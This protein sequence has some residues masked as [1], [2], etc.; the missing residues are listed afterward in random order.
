MES[1]SGP[2]GVVPYRD[3]VVR[4]TDPAGPPGVPFRPPDPGR[5]DMPLG[6]V[7]CRLGHPGPAAPSS[8]AFRPTPGFDPLRARVRRSGRTDPSSPPASHLRPSSSSAPSSAFPV[9]TH[10]GGTATRPAFAR[11]QVPVIPPARRGRGFRYPRP[12]AP[13]L[14]PIRSLRRR[15]V[16]RRPARRATPATTTGTRRSPTAR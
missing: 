6:A 14:R 10:H 2:E 9:P 8:L 11:N 13:K 5:R 1:R 12:F 4:R 15:S 3:A 7:P 16:P